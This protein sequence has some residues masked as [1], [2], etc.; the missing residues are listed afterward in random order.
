MEAERV[1]E[2]PARAPGFEIVL[3]QSP[4]DID[5]W[6][7]DPM[8]R[9][10]AAATRE[11]ECGIWNVETATFL[12]VYQGD[13][14]PC[15]DWLPL[16]WMS[17]DADRLEFEDGTL[18]DPARVY[19]DLELPAYT[20]DVVSGVAPWGAV[21]IAYGRQRE[22]ERYEPTLPAQLAVYY[23]P[24]DGKQWTHVAT[25]RRQGKHVRSGVDVDPLGRFVLM[26]YKRS[27]RHMKEWTTLAV[28]LGAETTAL[29][30]HDVEHGFGSKFGPGPMRAVEHQ[31]SRGQYAALIEETWFEQPHRVLSA[32]AFVLDLDT[33]VAHTEALPRSLLTRG[34]RALYER[35]TLMAA[36]GTEVFWELCY[37]ENAD[38]ARDD[39]CIPRGGPPMPAGALFHS[40]DPSS[41]YGVYETSKHG[42]ALRPLSGEPAVDLG[43][44]AYFSASQWGAAWFAMGQTGKAPRV[45]VVAIPG[46][47]ALFDRADASLVEPVPYASEL[48][49]VVVRRGGGLTILAGPE[50]EPIAEIETDRTAAVAFSPDGEQIALSDGTTV[51]VRPFFDTGEFVEWRPDAAHRIGWRQDGRVLWT[52]AKDRPPQAA[53]D[54]ASGGRRPDGDVPAGVLAQIG[55]GTALDPSWRWIATDG[56]AF[57]RLQDGERLVID[58]RGAM[59]ARGLYDDLPT[60]M[61]QAQ[62]RLPGDGPWIDRPLTPL[63]DATWL[64]RENLAH[65]FFAGVPFA[66]PTGPPTIRPQ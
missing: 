41:R 66:V 6:R 3:P 38:I 56:H 50:A 13:G 19:P 1:V 30:Y 51:E 48:G 12:G 7:F 31:W 27:T 18:T 14:D 28:P 24:A 53:W 62:I 52:A 9:Y 36:R 32:T 49:R 39:Q 34:R 40:F 11:R 29:R 43:F 65:D 17:G 10:L 4:R 54:P 8:G 21:A 35:E 47:K 16:W 33:G 63:V 45:R 37:Q 61:A 55:E 44:P 25:P 5:A 59:L 2:P 26:H 42:V 46:G 15:E 23:A 57:V 20:D 64:R 22:R 60:R 58:Q